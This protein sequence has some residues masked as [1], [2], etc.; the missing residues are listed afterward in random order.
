MIWAFVAGYAI[1]SL[2]T[3]DG[4][5]RLAGVNL[6]TEGSGNPGT[7]N[8]IRLGGIRLGATV[9][10]L[11]LIKGAGAV[12]LGRAMAG[13]AGGLAA[14]FT[15]M[16]GQVLNPWYGLRGGKGL[17]VAGGAA[18]ALWPPGLLVIGPIIA[19]AALLFRSAWAS[20]I[21]ITALVALSI[22][23]AS[24]G[25]STWWG[26]RADDTLVWFALAVLAVAGPKFLAEIPGRQRF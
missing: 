22:L 16:L 1:G 23:W 14:A 11:D 17:G 13:D 12:V 6:R 4:V 7:A 5:A 24:E 26:A 9:L 25:W 2:P 21:G 3:A 20:L 8:A 18:A 15:V 10:A 19:G